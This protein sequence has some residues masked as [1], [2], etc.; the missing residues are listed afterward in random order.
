MSSVA[1]TG[2]AQPFP[3][4]FLFGGATAANQFEGGFNEDGRGLA[5]VDLCPAGSAREAV[6]TGHLSSLSLDPAQHYPSHLGV[7]H[8]HHVEEDIALLAEM[9]CGVYRFSIAWTRI[10]PTGKETTPN[11]AGLAFYDRIVDTC[12]AHGIE[13]LVTICHF[14][15]PVH[16]IDTIGGW[17]SR[18]M[19]DHYLQLCQAL[20]THFAGRVKYWLTFNEIN[21]IMHAPFLG[22]G[23]V[24]TP[25]DNEEAVKYQAAHHELVAS[26]LATKLAHE[27]DPNFAVGC[28]F[29]AGVAYPFSCRPEDVWAA[30]QVDRDSY[31]FIDIQ[32]RGAYP[33]Y[34]LR[35]LE[36]NNIMPVMEPGDAEILAEHTVDFISFSYYNS[37]TTADSS[38]AAEQMSGN[39]FTT[40][41]NPYLEYSDWGWSIDPLGLRTTVNDIW[42]R[43]QK[44]LFVVENGIGVKDTV[45][46]DGSIDDPQRMRFL[47]DHLQALKDA[48]VID[49]CDVLGFTCWGPI[50]LVSAST[51]EMSKRY[52]FIYVDRDDQGNGSFARQKKASFDWYAKVIATHGAD[53]SLPDGYEV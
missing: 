13:P 7:D 38:T 31:F 5:N 50:D 47:R 27:I 14:D 18:Q 28:M 15:C 16:L 44:P 20:F 10:F 21:M 43:Y 19:I 29:A 53:L 41:K 30:K 45:N 52:G 42:D 40:V 1:T 48:I 9:G 49:G 22:A 24:F 2:A 34:A 36:R 32:S 17:R 25:G 35:Y 12:R 26:A 46:P 51:G 39:L 37:R 6:I 8:Y 3:T 23:L 33:N 4:G 11:A